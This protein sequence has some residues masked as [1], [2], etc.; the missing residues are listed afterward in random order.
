MPHWWGPS[1][2]LSNSLNFHRMLQ[3]LYYNNSIQITRVGSNGFFNTA[4]WLRPVT[5]NP[6]E[7]TKVI[8]NPFLPLCQLCG[9]ITRRTLVQT[10]MVISQ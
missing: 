5:D 4:D 10:C 6:L 9:T 1:A 3:G 8:K 2:V 7:E